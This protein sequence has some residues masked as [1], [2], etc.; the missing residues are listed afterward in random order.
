MVAIPFPISTFPGRTPQEGGG[1]L[2]N[3]LAEAMGENARASA[4]RHRVPG[5]AA[6]GTSSETTFRGSLLDGSTLYTAFED[7]VVSFTDAGGA[8]SPVDGL[9]GS[10]KVFFAKN[11]RRPTA[12]IL[13]VTSGGI[14]T[15]SGGVIADLSDP[16]LPAVNALVFLDGFFFVTSA[17]GRTFASG[18]NATTFN[19]ND[20]I[21]TEAKADILYRPVAFNG[22]LLLCG[23]GSIEVWDGDQINATG[24]PY[25]RTAV[26]QRGIAGQFAIAG[27]EDGFGKGLLF[28]GDDNSVHQLSGYDP[29]KVS[30]PDLDRLIAAVADKSTLEASVYISGGHPKWVLS[31]ADWTWEFDLNT[32]KWNERVSYQQTRWRGTGCFYAFNKWLCGDTLTGDIHEISYQVNDEVGEP[33]IAEVWSAPVHDFPRR[34][35]CPRVDF[36]FSTAVGIVAGDEPNETDPMVEVSYSDDGGYKF[37]NPRLKPLG[38]VGKPLTRI[39]LTACGMTGPQGRIWKIRMSDP[40]HF[41]LMAGDMSTTSM[42]S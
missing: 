31:C 29:V 2:I 18:L 12:D 7:E 14:F 15:M 6:W 41:G 38:K 9:A 39:T 37:S 21:T 1:R 30:P 32:Q 24:F 26:I 28:V 33:L 10:G 36:D 34:M 22:H 5:L 20:F 23:S 4:V 42:A 35:R 8:A 25:N 11:N 19:S 40:R 16:D 27:F 3:V 13:I 17:D